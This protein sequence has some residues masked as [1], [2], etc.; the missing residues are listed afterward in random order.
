MGFS[1]Q[2]YWSGVPLPSLKE[3]KTEG[4]FQIRPLGSRFRDG[5]LQYRVFVGE[6]PWDEHLWREGKKRSRQK[7]RASCKLKDSR[8]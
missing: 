4:E 8:G 6:Y 1:R 5:D 3:D 7:P 2:E